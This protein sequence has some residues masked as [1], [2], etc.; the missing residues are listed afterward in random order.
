MFGNITVELILRLQNLLEAM[1]LPIETKVNEEVSI[2][3]Q[4]HGLSIMYLT[5]RYLD[6]VNQFVGTF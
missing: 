4:Y 2:G 5:S 3:F 1:I 6:R